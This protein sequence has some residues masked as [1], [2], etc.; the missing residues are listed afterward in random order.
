[1][2]STP[3]G[4]FINLSRLNMAKYAARPNLAKALFEYIFHHENDV[5]NVSKLPNY[6]C[7]MCAL[8]RLTYVQEPIFSS[9]KLKNSKFFHYF[10][11]LTI[12]ELFMIPDHVVMI[13][14]LDN[15]LYCLS[16]Y[17][18]ITISLK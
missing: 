10:I 4:P 16:K 8:C 5:R 11:F 18:S 3:D 15:A 7:M 12:D 2:L 14:N 9:I 17:V 1:M 6:K 13:S